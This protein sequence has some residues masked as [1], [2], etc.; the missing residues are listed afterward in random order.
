MYTKSIKSIPDY[1]KEIVFVRRL[2]C[3]EPVTTQQSLR[4]YAYIA[5]VKS[6]PGVIKNLSIPSVWHVRI[7][8]KS[9]PQ[10]RGRRTKSKMLV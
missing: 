8:K 6:I 4:T 2:T 1:L 10:K 5:R 7:R 3:E 9:Q